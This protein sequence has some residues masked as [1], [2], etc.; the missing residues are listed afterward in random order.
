MKVNKVLFYVLGSCFIESALW[1]VV[2]Y[3]PLLLLFLPTKERVTSPC[4][5]S[6]N[7]HFLSSPANLM[8]KSWYK[9]N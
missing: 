7:D 8:P 9:S 1:L 4:V 5:L 2:S 6:L 3:C